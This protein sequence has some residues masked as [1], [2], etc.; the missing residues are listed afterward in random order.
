MTRRVLPPLVIH[1][2]IIA[3]EESA[4]LKKRKLILP[5][6]AFP[7]TFYFANLKKESK[8]CRDEAMEAKLQG[9]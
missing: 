7:F 2:L 4:L 9:K 1:T 6:F 3:E 8:D 5:L